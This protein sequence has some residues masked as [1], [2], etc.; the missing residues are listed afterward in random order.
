VAAV[1]AALSALV[2][3]VGDFLGGLSA[4]RMAA[5]LTAAVAQGTGLALLVVAAVV[6]GGGPGPSDWAWGAAAGAFGGGALLLF[7][8]AM[9]HGQISVVAPL[10]AVTS[11][12]VPFVVGLTLGDRPS[13][14]ALLGAVMA[15]PAI[16][17][18]SRE[19]DD[20]PADDADDGEPIAPADTPHEPPPA[21]RVL[22]A[23]LLAGI[24]FGGFLVCISRVGDDSGLWPLVGARGTTT[25]LMAAAALAIAGRPDRVGVRTAFAAGCC[26][27][28][29]NVL[30]LVAV[31][32]GMLSLVGVISSMYPASAV[33][34]ARLVLRERLATHQLA[35]LG[36]GAL[37]VAAVATG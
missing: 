8:W 32:Q 23:A 9:G 7:Y 12:L 34:L 14:V 4:R 3:G 29:A 36:L 16:V 21:G 37:A 33:L 26:D 22:V 15:L 13:S 35:G 20:D 19:P 27:V 5:S 28:T 2:F 30:Y 31:R 1:V 17:L 10:S 18:I 11:A 24:G 6:V 25:A